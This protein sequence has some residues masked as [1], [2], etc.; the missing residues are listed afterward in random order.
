MSD[1]L[2]ALRRQLDA[3]KELKGVVRAMKAISASGLRQY[4]KSVA[5]LANY[6]GDI[7][8]G[9]HV[10][11]RHFREPALQPKANVDA[12]I[13]MIIF[14]SDQ[15]LV[16]QF[17]EVIADFAQEHVSPSAQPNIWTVGERLVDCL[18]DRGYSRVQCFTLPNSLEN[19]SSLIIQLLA[20]F[21]EMQQS[22]RSPELRVFH[23]RP[24]TGR[25]FEPHGQ[26]L[27]P[28]DLE[29]GKEIEGI[30][31]ATDQIPQVVGPPASIFKALLREYIFASLFQAC[32][33]S[34]ASENASRLV[35]MQRAEKN[36][37][38]LSEEQTKRFHRVRQN[39]ID[40]ELF[41]VVASFKPS[42]SRK[43]R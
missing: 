13:G 7:R 37:D 40:D 14:G 21:D 6:Y 38:E 43:R 24:K 29:W 11:L 4:E 41:D 30:G 18:K 23:H 12:K 35:A 10:C 31:W 17:N 1:G 5:S 33:D 32:V 25:T 22:S 20:A 3:M 19:I 34:L 42:R 8:L 39:S 27:F 16:G 36:I 26:R 28:I 2:E 9:L 15:G